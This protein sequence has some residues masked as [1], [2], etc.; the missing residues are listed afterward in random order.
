MRQLVRLSAGILVPLP[1]GPGELAQLLAAV[2][3]LRG[4]TWQ[5][6]LT[7]DATLIP[8]HRTPPIRCVFWGIA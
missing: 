8:E 7:Q 6:V 1:H 5:N 4:G 2:G 3:E